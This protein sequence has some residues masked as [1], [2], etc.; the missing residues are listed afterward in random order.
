MKYDEAYALLVGR[1]GQPTHTKGRNT[2]WCVG[3][4][5]LFSYTLT[6]VDVPEGRHWVNLYDKFT[7]NNSVW[8]AHRDRIERLEE[9]LAR[10]P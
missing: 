10:L 6:L 9:L 7:G 2:Q 8:V 4:E 3:T 5:E 1:F